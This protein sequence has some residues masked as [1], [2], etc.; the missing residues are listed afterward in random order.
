MS[1]CVALLPVDYSSIDV[2]CCYVAIDIG[3]SNCRV[4]IGTMS[5]HAMVARFPA[6]SKEELLKGLEQV[7]ELLREACPLLHVHGS[8]VA[9][10]GPI[11]DDGSACTVTNYAGDDKR[12]EMDEFPSSLVPAGRVLLLNDLEAT[13]HGIC[14]LEHPS[15]PMRL[16]EYFENVWGEE[17][18]GLHHGGKYLVLAVGTG[19]GGG[20]VIW[21]NA[22]QSFSIVALEPGHVLVPSVGSADSQI[23][24]EEK[25]LFDHLAGEAWKNSHVP[26]FEHF[27]SGRGL[28]SLYR[29]CISE[30]KRNDEKCQSVDLSELINAAKIA[31]R[32]LKEKGAAERALSLHYQYLARCAGTVCTMALL[33]R[34]IF[35][36]G[37]NGV[38][39]IAWIRENSKM[40]RKEFLNHP[41]AD[42]FEETPLF[43]QTKELNF[44]LIGALSQAEINFR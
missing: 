13:C 14:A 19:L 22:S 33:K 16:H 39:N 30:E 5:R 32:G 3:G 4:T 40:L 31:E 15:S 29:F 37:D 20:A 2:H 43:A 42:W 35:W 10:A 12:I 6:S 7:G 11:L 27:A 9:L 24:N 25:R 21:N 8:C 28:E 44:N 38:A 23:A 36:A 41:K 1:A 18:P 34:G 17:K 26:E